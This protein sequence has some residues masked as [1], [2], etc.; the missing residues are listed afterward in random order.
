MLFDV[1]IGEWW[2]QRSDVEGI[3]QKLGLDVVP[4]I[5][6]G[7]LLDMIGFARQGFLSAWGD[8]RAEGIVARPSVELKSRNGSRIITK[9][10]YKDF[11][12]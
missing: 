7:T 6:Q 3:A 10:K 12:R 11:Q 8:F 9:I 1:K 5:A 2:L 4:I